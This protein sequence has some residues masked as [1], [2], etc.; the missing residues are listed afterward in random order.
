MT[1]IEKIEKYLLRQYSIANKKM[2]KEKHAGNDA[3]ANEWFKV[4]LAHMRTLNY[5]RSL[6]VFE[7]GQTIVD[8]NH[9]EEPLTITE[10]RYDKYYYSGDLEICRIKDQDKWELAEE[11]N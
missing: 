3:A 5:V 10:I 7:V 9:R 2:W 11:E 1:N 6:P 8:K 4:S